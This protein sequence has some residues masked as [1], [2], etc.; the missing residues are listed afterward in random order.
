M[1]TNNEMLT[2]QNVSR[3]KSHSPWRKQRRLF[4]PE[5]AS[6]AQDSCEVAKKL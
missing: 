4:P 3:K 1:Y 2:P 6:H 5:G